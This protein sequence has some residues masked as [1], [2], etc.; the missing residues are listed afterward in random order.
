M[1]LWIESTKFVLARFL[2][3]FHKKR[4]NKISWIQQT[5]V[6]LDTLL[7]FW[8]GLNTKSSK[9]YWRKKRHRKRK[10]E[11]I[12]AHVVFWIKR[13][14]MESLKEEILRSGN[15]KQLTC[16]PMTKSYNNYDL[17]ILEFFFQR[18]IF[19]NKKRKIGFA[20]APARS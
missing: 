12:Q 19:K 11:E 20:A 13:S 1:N 10:E 15:K 7:N 2:E 3:T 14:C 8:K 5:L 6:L 4:L 9:N 18:K 17:A 16:K